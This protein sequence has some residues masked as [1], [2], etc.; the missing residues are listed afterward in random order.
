MFDVFTWM[1]SQ[2]M[3]LSYLCP[4]F[5]TAEDSVFFFFFACIMFYSVIYIMCVCFESVYFINTH[6]CRRRG[7]R[8]YN[9]FINNFK[10]N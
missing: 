2:Q 8:E 4:F 5:H 9:Y 3:D 10:R 6:I 1:F 7:E